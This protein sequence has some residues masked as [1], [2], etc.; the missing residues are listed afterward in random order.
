M[1][2]LSA[3]RLTWIPV[4]WKGV[5]DDEDGRGQSMEHEIECRVDL[6]D[7]DRMKEIFPA[8]ADEEAED[9][10][11]ELSNLE[12]FKALTKDWR[13]VVAGGKPVPFDDEAISKMLRLP[14]FAQGFEMSYLKA[15]MGQVEYREKNS[16]ALSA[17][18]AADKARARSTQAKKPAQ[19]KKPT[20]KK[21]APKKT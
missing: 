13:G 3:P 17:G 11:E 7:S 1:F 10:P 12:K 16:S 20:P 18:G 6:V 4:R 8:A 14:N 2:D 9:G 21:R 5:Q 15:W 19:K